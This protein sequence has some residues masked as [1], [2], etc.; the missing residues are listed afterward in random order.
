MDVL[1]RAEDLLGK[2][3]GHTVGQ[4]HGYGEVAVVLDELAHKGQVI[5][6]DLFPEQAAPK[7]SYRGGSAF[8]DPGLD[9]TQTGV[10]THGLGVRGGHLHS[11]VFGRIVAGGNLHGGVEAVV[12]R[13]EVYHRGRTEADIIDVRSGIVDAADDGVANLVRRDAAVPTQQYFIG[14]QKD[15]DEISHFICSIQ[16]PVF[17]PDAAD[18][19]CVKCAHSIR[20]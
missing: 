10:V 18:V 3:V 9:L 2:E 20:F 12:G 8:I 6:H 15:R 11:V 17:S 5:G 4:V 13:A 16:V 1:A 19:I 14:F 7:R